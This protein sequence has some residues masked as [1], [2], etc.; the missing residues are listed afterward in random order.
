MKKDNL[1]TVIRHSGAYGIN[2]GRLDV[3]MEGKK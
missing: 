3:V 1:S 2:V